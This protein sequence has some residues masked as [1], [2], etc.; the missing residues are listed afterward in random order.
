[1]AD[2]KEVEITRSEV[3]VV[4]SIEYNN[5]GDMVITDKEGKTYKI[6]EKR[7][8]FFK[9]TLA[10]DMASKLN[11]ASAYNKEYIYNATPVE[12]ELPTFKGR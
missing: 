3:I 2:K 7:V 12:G 10:V 1:M 9:D 6:G 8:H 5:Y 4:A 11:F